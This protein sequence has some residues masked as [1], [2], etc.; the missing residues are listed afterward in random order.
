ML[1]KKSGGGF[2][3]KGA[4]VA[5]L[6]I[7]AVAIGWSAVQHAEKQAR[8]R[9]AVAESS[10]GPASASVEASASIAASVDEL[11]TQEARVST[12]QSSA[13]AHAVVALTPDGGCVTAWDSR[14]QQSGSYGVYLQRFDAA[15][16]PVGGETQVNLRTQ[17]MQM[18]PALAIDA[19]GGTWVA[20]E[21]FGQDGSM[22]SI[23]ARRFGPDF[24][25]STDE[26]L[27]NKTV[28]GHQ[29]DVA[30]DVDATGRAFFVW[31]TPSADDRSRVVM[32]RCFDAAGHAVTDEF[33]VSEQKDGDGVAPLPCVAVDAKNRSVVAWAATDKTGDLQGVRFRAFNANGKALTAELPAT[34]PGA[35]G[36]GGIEP[37][38]DVSDDGTVVLA[39]L[40]AD[41]ADYAV[42][43]RR[44]D[45]EGKPLG[46]TARVNEEAPGYVSGVAVAAAP[47][48]RH[49][50]CWNNCR[51]EKEESDVVGRFFAADGAALG[52]TKR[53]NVFQVG[54]QRLTAASGKRRAAWSSDNRLAIAW[55]GNS[56]QGDKSA[57][58]LTLLVPKDEPCKLVSPVA[59]APQVAAAANQVETA[60]GASPFQPPTYD[61]S[62]IPDE[63][64]GGDPQPFAMGTDNGFIA[65]TNS[66]WTPPDPHLA[67]GPEHL[68]VMTNGAIAFFTEDGQKTFEDEIEDDYGFWGELGTTYFVFDPEVIY[69]PH[70]DRFIAM[71]NERTSISGNGDS[72]F[73]LAVSDDSNP[74]GTWYKYR[75]NVTSQ[76]N[77]GDIDSPN[78]AVDDEAVYLTADF[79]GPD[80][81]LVF[82]VEK[83]ALLSGGTPIT[84]HLL[85]TGS[86]SYGIPVTYDAN[87]P[88]QYMIQTFEAGSSDTI[89]MHA[90]YNPLTHPQRLTIDLTVPRYYYPEDPPQRG[91]SVRPE[92]F[93]PRFWSCVYRNG[94]LWAVHHHG[95][96][97]V[98]ARWYE[99]KMNNWPFVGQPQL[100]QWGEIDPG[101]PVRTFFPSIWVDDAGNAVI[102]CARSSPHG[103]HLDVP[104]VAG[105][106]RSAGLLPP[107]GVRAGEL[108]PVQLRPLGRLLRNGLASDGG[109]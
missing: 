101:S 45:R 67:V 41:D 20:W 30:V 29:A 103:V 32:A 38:I 70:S 100:A 84:R 78:L 40:A 2:V 96:D 58:N 15:G 49:L 12:F 66:G 48:G 79:F 24:A 80:K 55:D 82:I 35:P 89:R 9:S 43:A 8:E 73:L 27:I 37:S 104:G 62:T 23:L 50:I 3:L 83:A 74:N 16:A 4:L 39:W 93:E 13:Q 28:A 99:F 17:G 71:A 90:I 88:A 85:I 26:L 97:R 81:Y 64:F 7:A 25:S 1:G 109:G 53:I 105:R 51:A 42:W 76:G 22:G 52:T 21:S 6:P 72:Y 77:G 44:F 60:L 47:D 19:Q 65:I 11:V 59:E 57:A 107:A 94:S 56:G 102:T 34:Q 31:T 36:A 10:C 5:L 108:Q 92:L 95:G 46:A 86:Q 98:R 18:N 91:T 54:H 68:V 63:P 75:F 106:R 61:P 33:R 87:A 14:R 69:D